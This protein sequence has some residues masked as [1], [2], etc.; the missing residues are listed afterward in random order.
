MESA[1]G[2]QRVVWLLNSGPNLCH[3]QEEHVS[4]LTYKE[5]GTTSGAILKP[6]NALISVQLDKLRQKWSPQV[7]H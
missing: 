7:L 2:L 6:V 3:P 5:P 1:V 4:L